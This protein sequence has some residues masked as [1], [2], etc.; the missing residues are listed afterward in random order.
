MSVDDEL[1]LFGT[2]LS[3]VP[4]GTDYPPADQGHC[5]AR[6]IT[7]LGRSLIL[8][9]A[10]RGIMIDID[11]MSFRMVND[12]LS[13]AEENDFPLSASHAYFSDLRTES[14]ERER[15]RSQLTRMSA[16]GGFLAPITNQRNRERP[17][18]EE[19]TRHGITNPCV[20]SSRDFVTSVLYIEGVTG[21]LGVPFGSD[22][23][24]I[25]RL[26]GPRFGEGG[27]D[28]EASPLTYPFSLPTSL[29]P[30]G[31]FER[32]VSGNVSFDFNQQGL[33]NIGLLP[34]FLADVQSMGLSQDTLAPLYNSAEAFVQTWERAEAA[35][36]RLSAPG[37]PGSPGSPGVPGPPG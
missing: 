23:N 29:V 7:E 31:T 32:L 3:G 8:G 28:G 9:A 35:A 6:G 34:D 4:D 11:H 33:A 22:V 2:V 17:L 19:V 13:L 24:G 12:V 37:T 1:E 20:G 15:T 27:C 14:S 21:T 30:S 16:L 36:A 25:A 10:E 18:P 26:M 5:N